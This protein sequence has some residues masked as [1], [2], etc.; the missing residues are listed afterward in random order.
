MVEL[1]F[2]IIDISKTIVFIKKIYTQGYLIG[3]L[4][5]KCGSQNFNIYKGST[6]KINCCSFSCSNYK[7]KKISYNY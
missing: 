3:L 7:C 2:K 4:K 1:E 6:Y 5:C